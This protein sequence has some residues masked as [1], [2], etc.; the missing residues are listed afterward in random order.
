MQRILVANP[1]GGSGKTTVS[2][3]LAG[4]FATR[5]HR[6]GIADFDRQQSSLDWLSRR[7]D[8]LAK[9]EGSNGRKDDDEPDVDWLIMDSPGGL[10]GDKLEECIKKADWIIVPT[11]PSAFDLGVTQEFLELLRAE[12]AIRKQRTFLG[13]IGM[14]A[15][16]HTNAGQR[17]STFMQESELTQ[18]GCLRNAQVYATVA[19]TGSSVFDLR[20][21]LVK[22]DLQQ[23][24][25]VLH[26]L[27]TSD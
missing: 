4:Y 7:S 27:T 19:E 12:K 25:P 17:L 24:A 18:L 3:N 6:V 23:W 26:W 1:K 10:H 8:K 22:R 13:V 15:D 2:T 5:G 20:P 9:I 11:Q 14:R 16:M 21:S